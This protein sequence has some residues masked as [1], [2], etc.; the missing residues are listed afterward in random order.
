[1]AQIHEAVSIFQFHSRHCYII[2]FYSFRMRMLP[3]EGVISTSNVILSRILA[4]W[5]AI[6]VWSDQQQ[7]APLTFGPSSSIYAG[8]KD[9]RE[10]FQRTN[11][12]SQ[13]MFSM[14][15]NDSTAEATP[16]GKISSRQSY[17]LTS[18]DLLEMLQRRRLVLAP[19]PKPIE[20]Q[21]NAST[22]A[23]AEGSQ[24][25]KLS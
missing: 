21:E 16:E 17:D 14:L 20:G 19:P 10:S 6:E 12:S 1:M 2:T 22:T 13:N 9:K 15:N 4:G 5:K 23:E 8:K 7:G 3:R 24:A 18:F 11:S 25:K